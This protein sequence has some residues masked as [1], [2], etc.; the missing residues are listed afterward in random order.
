[1]PHTTV[2]HSGTLADAPDKPGLGDAPHETLVTAVAGRAA[3]R[4]TR[5][6]R[7]DDR[8]AGAAARHAQD[9]GSAV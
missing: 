5:F 6:V 2:E 4:T 7:H 3:G 8:H 1:M 9:P